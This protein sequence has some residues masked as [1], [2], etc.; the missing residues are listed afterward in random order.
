MEPVFTLSLGPCAVPDQAQPRAVGLEHP[1]AYV[2][3][4]CRAVLSY[5]PAGTLYVSPVTF[6]LNLTSFLTPQKGFTKHQNTIRHKDA[7]EWLSGQP[8]PCQ[9]HLLYIASAFD[10]LAKESKSTLLLTFLCGCI[11]A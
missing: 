7:Y 1:I 10:S 5:Q 3:A 6:T 2:L 4:I 11:G 8:F 9:S